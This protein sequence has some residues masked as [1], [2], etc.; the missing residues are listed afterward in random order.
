M[1]MGRSYGLSSLTL[2]GITYA[3]SHEAALEL[4]RVQREAW[5]RLKAD[6]ERRR[7]E[8]RRARRRTAVAFC[9]LL[10]ALALCGWAAAIMLGHADPP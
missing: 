10:V 5:A 7:L 4:Q 1:T 3:A 2:G 6:Q 8:V 9:T